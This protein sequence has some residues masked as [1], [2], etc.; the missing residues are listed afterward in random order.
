MKPQ[1][2]SVRFPLTAQIDDLVPAIDV[3]HRF[4]QRGLVEGLILDV[5]DYRHVPDGPGVMLIGH[6]VDYAVTGD[7]L[8]VVRKRS[9]DDPATT[10][11]TDAVRMGLGMATAIA[12]DGVLPVTIDPSQATVTVIDRRLGTP[13]EVAD[14]LVAE[15]GPAVG[16]VF[17]PEA[18]VT[19]S[20]PDDPRESPT[21][22]VAAP[23]ATV[24]EVLDRLGG[25]RAPGQSP[26]DVSV[27]EL[28]RLREEQADFVLLDVREESE[29][30]TANL[31]G[32]L[33]PLATLDEQI[34][35][36]DRDAR[37]LVHCRSGHRGAQAVEQLRSAGFEDAWNVNGGLVAWSDEY[38]P[39]LPVA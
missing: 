16:D 27:E 29:Y 18:T 1:R 23:T 32:H 26:W 20:P 17:G 25:S 34:D 8:F 14:A 11:L 31:G 5:A 21:V 37:I 22:Q 38:D 7:T 4:I 15:V 24:T 39:A 28:A 12:E 9:G 10:Q 33:V 13:D 2:L 30:E 36:L 35:E 3:F 19:A 6:D